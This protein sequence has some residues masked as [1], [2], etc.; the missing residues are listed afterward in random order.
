MKPIKSKRDKSTFSEVQKRAQ[1]G[2]LEEASLKDKL[3]I[4]KKVQATHLSPR[5]ENQRKNSSEYDIKC[6]PNTNMGS[7]LR[8]TGQQGQAQ[9]VLKEIPLIEIN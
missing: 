2:F 9:D 6:Q 8:T 1:L 3:S 7:V 4:L 5:M